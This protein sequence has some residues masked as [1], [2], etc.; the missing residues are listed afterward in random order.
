MK[1]LI[2]CCFLLVSLSSFSQVLTRYTDKSGKIGFI[3]PLKD[4]VVRARFDYAQH[5]YFGHKERPFCIVANNKKYGILDQT[6]KLILDLNY[7]EIS[8][9]L[10][11][12][13]VGVKSRGKY[14]IFSLKT[15]RLEIS[16][17]YTYAPE[18][19]YNVAVVHENGK[20]GL[21][22]THLK[23]ILPPQY[24]SIGTIS[25]KIVVVGNENKYGYLNLQGKI[26][27]PL[28]Y[29]KIED[30]PYRF[31]DRIRVRLGDKWGVIDPKGE[32][33]TDFVYDE[34]QQYSSDLAGF[35]RDGKG[36]YIN[37]DGKVVIPARYDFVDWFEK[38]IAFVGNL[39]P[40]DSNLYY[41][42]IDK[43]GEFIIPCQFDNF[44][45][46]YPEDIYFVSKDG[47]TGA[48]N[49]DAKLIVPIEYENEDIVDDFEVN[50]VNYILLRKNGKV[51]MIDTKG[52]EILPAIYDKIDYSD[53]SNDT[54]VCVYQNGKKGWYDLY[55]MRMVVPTNYS[56]IQV[57]GSESGDFVEVEKEGKV[58][59]WNLKLGKEVVPTQFENM[60]E[61]TIYGSKFMYFTTVQNAQQGLWDATNGIE[62]VPPLYQFVQPVEELAGTNNM[63]FFGIVNEQWSL[64]DQLGKQIIPLLYTQ[65]PNVIFDGSQKYLIVFSSENQKYGLFD[66]SG[67]QLLPFDYVEINSVKNGKVYA[68]KEDVQE[69]IDLK[70][71]NLPSR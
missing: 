37:R 23:T 16:E 49:L 40:T 13:L 45:L 63:Y 26:V 18:F 33:I 70:K 11:N 61:S 12:E 43:T 32:K 44:E 25:K 47:K 53:H 69:T 4:T 22:G 34:I 19:I 52:K 51:K 10:V 8:Q 55:L 7:D 64:Y 5:T 9:T 28:I 50:S 15:K 39:N 14:G 68:T 27:V 31:E 56:E 30:N 29:D 46:R 35:Y 60:E 20:Y 41:G 17:K 54:Y 58:G 42:V 48:M 67:K 21:L 38:K 3:N 59:V 6:G 36:G 57:I 71:L 66:F 62:I 1:K 65:L 24:D 2:A